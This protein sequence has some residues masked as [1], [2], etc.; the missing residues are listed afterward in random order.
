MSE[1]LEN[2]GTVR[3]G[4]L[5]T[6]NEVLNAT[7]TDDNGPWLSKRLADLGVDVDRQIV[8]PDHLEAIDSGLRHLAGRDLDL[9]IT[10]GGLGPTADDKTAEAVAGFAGRPLEVDPGMEE[11]IGAILRRY[12]AARGVELPAD[13]LDQANRKQA[14]VPQGAEPLDPV[15]TAPGLV[16]P[17]AEGPLVVVLPGPPRELRPMFEDAL[18][19]TAMKEV[20][21][22]AS[23]LSAYTVRM[24]GTPE[25]ELAL[26]LR[27]IE[28]EGLD[29]SGLSVT[30]CL[31]KGELEI[32]VRYRDAEAG[33]AEE[34]RAA[35]V[36]RFP[37][38]TFS[39]DGTGIDEIVAG[40]L[41]DRVLAVAESCSAGLLAS[42]IAARPGS[43]EYFAGGVVTYS[44]ESKAELLG[45]D[46]E[47]IE[48]EG[49]VSPEVARAMA[50]G[51]LARFG[52]DTAAAITGVAG[53][54]GGTEEKPVGFVC[55]HVVADGLGDSDLAITIPGNRN[56]I[57]ERSALVAMHMIRRLLSRD[58]PAF[59]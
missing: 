8:V 31:R 7:I 59:R 35:L 43:S 44:N 52:A 56:D 6:G 10:T 34:L 53:P 9:I 45:V 4:I 40:L 1:T 51:A 42:R 58:G 15:G 54:G 41:R 32:D 5:V 21:G 37:K 39:T 20:L 33:N 25:S 55:F 48:Q 19:T 13:G 50:L 49:A 26:G 24:F 38:T 47:L 23:S 18:G 57:R 28:E 17:V 46:P 2:A 29:L 16:V 36:D 27:E 3:A 14:L 12:A 11:K 30:T 22:R